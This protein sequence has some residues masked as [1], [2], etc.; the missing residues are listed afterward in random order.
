MRNIIFVS[1]LALVV[2]LSFDRSVKASSE[3]VEL[4]SG[5]P[6]CAAL[7][8]YENVVG[9]DFFPEAVS[10]VYHSPGK[11]PWEKDQSSYYVKVKQYYEATF[12]GRQYYNPNRLR[13]ESE[14]FLNSYKNITKFWESSYDLSSSD[15]F[16]I[17]Y[18]LRLI[19]I[20]C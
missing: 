14:A 20:S 1:F 18:S 15:S 10:A 8:A 16:F 7:R 6:V 17:F 9:G 19:A 5:S 13:F 12:S 3:R 4:F 2:F 11:N